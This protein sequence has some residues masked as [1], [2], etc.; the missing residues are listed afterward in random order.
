M[1]TAV[2]LMQIS[3]YSTHKN[4]AVRKIMEATTDVYLIERF[5]VQYSGYYFYELCSIYGKPHWQAK[6]QNIQ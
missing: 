4:L 6:I 5:S 2:A 3:A 1:C